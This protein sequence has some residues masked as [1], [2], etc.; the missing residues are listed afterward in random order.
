MGG[1]HRAALAAFDFDGRHADFNQLGQHFEHIQAGG[2]FKCV[3]SFIVDFEAAFAERGIARGLVGLELVDEHLV[4][5]HVHFVGLLLPAHGFGRRTH[6]LHIGRFAGGIA[7]QNA[8]AFHHH[9]QTAE[10]EHFHFHIGVVDNVF[11]LIDG[12][13]ARQH[14]A[15]D[16]E[17]FFHQI[18]GF[19]ISSRALHRHVQ[20][21]IGVAFAGIIHQRRIGNNH[22]VDTQTGGGIDG[23]LPLRHLPRLRKRVD[24]H[25]H[26]AAAGMGIGDAFGGGFHV[27]IE[28]GEIAGVGGIFQTHV[29]SVCAAVDGGFQGGKIACGAN[30]LRYFGHFIGSLSESG[31]DFLHER[32]IN[33]W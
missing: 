9:T 27:E 17:Q 14:H 18:D 20:A 30:Q 13:H 22:G 32:K 31:R 25:Q 10:T 5:A 23:F 26:M 7:R 29:N 8:A 4:E 1:V 2:L 24:G 12:E 28:A 16:A 19:V 21:Q 6:A 11:H 3:I 15:A 33:I